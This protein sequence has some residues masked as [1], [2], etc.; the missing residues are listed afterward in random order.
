MKKHAK[1]FLAI[2]LMVS[3]CL[4]GIGPIHAMAEETEGSA[5]T[6]KPAITTLIKS[7]DNADIKSVGGVKAYSEHFAGTSL[8]VKAD[9]SNSLA[10][11]NTLTFSNK[12]TFSKV[13]AGFSKTGLLSWGK[14]PGLN[15]DILQKYGFTGK[16]AV[17][18]YV[19]QP[20]KVKDNEQYK[21]ANVHYKNNSGANSSM[22][23][24]A[25]LSLLAGKD[26][27]T[28]PKAEVYYYAHAAWKG[29]QKTHAQC[30]Y[31]IIE[32]N[33]KL[34]KSKKITMVG[35]SDGIDIE[36]K[37]VEAFE[38]AVKACEDAGIMVW[39]C[40]DYSGASFIPNSDKN[41]FENLT[42]ENW[43]VDR[44]DPDLVYVP[45]SGRTTAYQEGNKSYIYWSEGG[46]SWTMPYMLGLYGI[47][48][49]I[50]PSL[51]KEDI[52]TLVVETAYTNT[53]GMRIVDPVEFVCT[54]LDKV[55][56]T[57]TAKKMRA[58]V[59]ARQSYTYAILNT[60]TLSEEDVDSIS[61]Y[62]CTITDSV[63]LTVDASA[64]KNVEELYEALVTDHKERGGKVAGIQIFGTPTSVPAF[65]IS[66]RV[67]M[68]KEID[69]GGT[70]LTDFF[71]SNFNNDADV[72]NESY[73]VYDQFKSNLKVDLVP[74]WPVVRLPL[75][76]GEFKAYFTNYNA[77][78]TKTALKKRTLV[79]FSNPIFP[80]KQH[81]DDM[82]QFLQRMTGTY[83]MNLTYRL[84]GNLDGQYPVT[85]KVLGNFTAANLQKENKKGNLEF[86]IN[87]HGQENNIDQA[88]FVNNEEQRKSLI[89]SENIN[90]ILSV[91]Y[92]YL[93]LWTCLNGCDMSD[94]LVTTALNGKCIGA[95]A[96]TTIISNNGVDNKVSVS[97]MKKSN[98]YYF[99]YTY[100]KALSG[101]SSRSTAFYK[102]QKAYANALL[103]ESKKKIDY[104]ANYQF[105]LYNLLC[106]ENF[107][108]ISS[109]PVVSS[110]YKISNKVEIS[111]KNNMESGPDDNPQ[112]GKAVLTDGKPLGEAVELED[113]WDGEDSRVKVNSI[114]YQKLDN[115]YIRFTIDLDLPCTKTI[116]VFNPPY[117]NLFMNQVKKLKKG[118]HVVIFDLPESMAM[119]AG[120]ITVNCMSE[121]DTSDFF[122]FSTSSID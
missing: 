12:T 3:L 117:G 21:N 85:T 98:F 78:A 45:S 9:L 24:P 121:D 23:G 74:Q 112:Y 33:K 94:N 15:I 51:T 101:G 42:Y 100:F 116:W 5:E 99:Y 44:G 28:A 69:E 31:Q 105:N 30:L 26:I 89:N 4:S 53:S 63:V 73:S 49:Q 17:V 113:Y 7:Y 66:Y 72:L 43:D 52:R 114:L 84:Y 59:K 80:S 75:E 50:D 62:L 91:N 57:S 79:N 41:N 70:V 14:Y 13:P 115:Q 58:E 102:A 36:E 37:N 118:N 8:K 48:K 56:R 34:P 61:Q 96:A 82:G 35:F 6:G 106:Y 97:K 39:F 18:A 64:Y 76:K 65:S 19:D 110:M 111:D 90:S 77:F 29:D 46:L 92:Y 40:Q 22:H 95:F 55:G 67:Q 68:E 120:I 122:A 27:G 71:Y 38:R 20:V 60:A 1:R 32:Q 83:K 109:N 103:T 16:G 54:V 88:I 93:D 25:V 11:A 47:V 10:L 108:V 104:G 87:S 86:I 119:E 107:G 2:L 81:T